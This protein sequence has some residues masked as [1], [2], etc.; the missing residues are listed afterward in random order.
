MDIVQALTNLGGQA[1]LFD[2]YNEVARIRTQSLPDGYENT[3]RGEIYR[4]TPGKT[5]FN[6]KDYFRNIERGVWALSNKTAFSNREKSTQNTVGSSVTYSEELEHIYEDG[7]E[8]SIKAFFEDL[9][10]ANLRFNS[11]FVTCFVASLLTKRFTILT[12]IAG[13]GK[14][15]LA[16]TFANWI[17]ENPEQICVVPVGADWTNRDPLLGFSNA[18]VKG[19]YVKPES[20][21]IDLL[22]RAEK[23]ASKPY[24]LILDEM[25]L[26]HVERYFAD[27]LSA[28]ESEEKIPLR[29]DDNEDWGS[30]PIP[31][32]ISI[33]NNL[34]I[35]GTVNVDETTYMFSPKVLDRAF[36]LEFRVSSKDM[37]D[38]LVNPLKED[39]SMITTSG[40]N[41]ATDF[42][43]KANKKYGDF[44]ASESLKSKISQ[45][46]DELEPLGSE[47]GYRTASEIYR[48]GAILSSLNENSEFGIEN[49]IDATVVS[50]LLPKIHGSR[51]KLE[52]PLISLFNLCFHNPQNEDIQEY[53][54]RSEKINGNE[55]VALDISL[56]KIV[57]MYQQVIQDGFTSFSEA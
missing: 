44:D 10:R 14:T 7:S 33:P 53:V 47:F 24:F 25:N 37:R 55:N 4:H 16:I 12:G 21:V 48:F 9:K 27:F 51:R 50:K 5:S 19:S 46:F 13:S 30:S 45:F 22:L 3:I 31:A 52:R 1:E 20:G 18:L 29:P 11:F 43:M 42:L 26:S 38:F 49:I 23:D 34:F 15:K 35:I 36:V 6:G 28:M 56:N 40:A 54:S 17:S 8:L 2:I 57:R 32:K 41:M 39:T